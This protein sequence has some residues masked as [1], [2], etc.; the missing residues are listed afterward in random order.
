[1]VSIAIDGPSGAGK[2]TLARKLAAELGF[3]YVDT[4]AL[5]RVVGLYALRQSAATKDEAAVAALLPGC[6]VGLA[7]VSG[8]QHVFLN[9]EDV[10]GD[11][12]REEVGMAASDV[13][14]HPPVRAFLL[15]TQRRLAR[16]H[17]VLM[18][19][20]DIGTVVLPRAQ[21]KIF[22]TASAQDRARRRTLELEQ[23]GLAA[24][25]ETILADVQTRD[26]N[27]SHRAASPL[28][29]AGD[30]LLVDTTG[31]S[32]EKSYGILLALLKERLAFLGE[33]PR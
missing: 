22:L 13:S 16:E 29:R 24:D 33:A 11:I 30:A 27:D 19:G 8:E 9:N 4:G 2:S 14:A 20:R 21:I 5:Y 12:R 25:Y 1:M 23:K 15:E 26:Y 6:R 7:Y 31:N 32:F 17:N 10:S 18:D 28:K 3:L